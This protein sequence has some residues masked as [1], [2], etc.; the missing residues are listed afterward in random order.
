M[1]IFNK[2]IWH[3]WESIQPLFYCEEDNKSHVYA[4]FMLTAPDRTG[5][6]TVHIV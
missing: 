4:V 2:R 5:R 3:L 6:I 1:F